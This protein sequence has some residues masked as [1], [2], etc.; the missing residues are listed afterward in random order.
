M[1]LTPEQSLHLLS[2]E[3][4]LKSRLRQKYTS[5]AEAHKDSDPLTSK[6][7]RELIDDAID[8]AIDT[9]VYLYTLR[10]KL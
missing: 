5:G 2:I 8:E 10:E 3:V 4:A 7:P 1:P 6:K 9:L